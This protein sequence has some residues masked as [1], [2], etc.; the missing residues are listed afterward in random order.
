MSYSLDFRQKV[1]NFAEN[2]GK[3]TK[4]AH[5]FGIGRASIYRW[6]FRPNIELTR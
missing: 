6:L 5:T 1:I 2:G 3:I 4:A